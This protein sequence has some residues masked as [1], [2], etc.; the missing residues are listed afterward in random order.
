LA[1][2]SHLHIGGAPSAEPIEALCDLKNLVDL[3]LSNVKAAET[4]SFLERMPQLK[5]LDLPRLKYLLISNQ[6]K[7]EEMAKLA[8]RLP[9]VACDRFKPIGEPVNW[10][11]CKKC[12]DHTGSADRQTQTLAV[13]NLRREAYRK[14]YRRIQSHLPP[15]SGR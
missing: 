15:S 4:L 10:N 3:E 14:A 2:L 9:S 7:M 11:R 1:K 12:G 8:G 5:S 6:F 13:Y